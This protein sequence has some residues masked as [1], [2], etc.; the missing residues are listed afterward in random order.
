M[1]ILIAT[2]HRNLVGGIER[3]VQRLIPALRAGGHN[4]ALLYEDPFDPAAA[5][6]DSLEPDLPAWCHNTRSYGDKMAAISEWGP[7]L[8]YSQGLQDNDLEEALLDRYPT[9][10]YAHNYYGTC[11]SG[12]KCHSFPGVRPCTRRFGKACLVL[13]YPR[14]CG[15]LNPVTMM[16][17]LQ[18]QSAINQRLGKYKTILVASGHM[19]R[20]FETHGVVP[21]KLVCAPLPNPE[22]PLPTRP[23]DRIPRGDLLFIGRMTEIKG[24]AFA[25]EAAQKASQQLGR[26]LRI[27]FAGDG[28][29][30][31]KLASMARNL[32][33]AVE[34]AGWVDDSRR[35]ALI[36]EADLL[37]VPSRW[38]E[39][40][41]LVG[42]EAG[43]LG[44]PAAGFAVGGIPDWLI[45]GISGE[46]APGDP[47]TVDGLAAATVRALA[48][49]AHYNQLR[50]GA[51][52]TARRFSMPAHL[53]KLEQTWLTC[54]NQGPTGD[55]MPRRDFES[56]VRVS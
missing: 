24:P 40:F 18:R 55:P 53:E 13:Y 52:T 19:H 56:R 32:D 39:P 21:E 50:I 45:P 48:D 4:V 3:Y 17:M 36:R 31:A 23:G 11:L 43:A 54:L 28:A 29:E 10:L 51:W 44:L 16:G 27:T 22:E 33:I 1:R 38:P 9:I 41:G 47:P 30:R 2:T 25:L 15:G 37:V 7:D 6:I 46:L 20:E 35:R 26:R 42:I 34:F 49:P 14:R 8:V 12:A 5:T